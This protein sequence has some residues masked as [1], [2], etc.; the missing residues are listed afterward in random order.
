MGLKENWNK[1]DEL[2]P[3]CHHTIKVAKGINKQNLKRLVLA[4]PKIEDWIILIMLIM[5]L[6]L[7]W[8]YNVET[9]QCRQILEDYKNGYTV[10]QMDNHPILP[11]STNPFVPNITIN[12]TPNGKT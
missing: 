4:K 6:L 1:T 3:N 2:C 9:K 5:T 11:N 8:R 7:A 10:L 12:L